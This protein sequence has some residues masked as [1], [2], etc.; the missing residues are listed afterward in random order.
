[1]TEIELLRERVTELSRLLGLQ[2]QQVADLIILFEAFNAG[3]FNNSIKRI[4]ALEARMKATGKAG[5]KNA[6]GIVKLER[7]ND[8]LEG[9]I[10]ALIIRLDKLDEPS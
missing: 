7:K 5:N 4:V 2:T 8:F 6:V 3:S 10:D 1:M 9:K